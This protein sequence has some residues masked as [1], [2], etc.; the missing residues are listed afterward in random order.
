MLDGGIDARRQRHR[1]LGSGLLAA[2]A[3]ADVDAV[4][5]TGADLL[6]PA[7]VLQQGDG[8]LLGAGPVRAGGTARIW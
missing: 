8:L 2:V 1:S 5:E 3:D 4:V 6:H 7:V